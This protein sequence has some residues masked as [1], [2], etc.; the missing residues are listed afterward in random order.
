[1]LLWLMKKILGYNN[2]YDKRLRALFNRFNSED[3]HEILKAFA[4]AKPKT[5][6]HTATLNILKERLGLNEKEIKEKYMEYFI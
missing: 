4:T 1:M 3:V 6:K 5:I 2:K